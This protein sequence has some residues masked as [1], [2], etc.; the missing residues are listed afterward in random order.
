[1]DILNFSNLESQILSLLNKG[2]KTFENILENS[3]LSEKT[4]AQV[5]EGLISK[6]IILL[7][8]KTN[9]YEYQ[10]KVN[11]EVLILDGNLLLPT[12]IIRLKDKI[13]VTRGEWYEFPVD[14]DIRRI[15]WN[16]KLDNK[17]NSTLV[18]LIRTSILKEKKSKL[19]Q[20]TEYESLVNKIVPY[21]NNIGLLIHCISETVT[22]ISIIFKIKLSPTEEISI[23]HR[24]FTVRSEISTKEL[25]DEL[26]LPTNERNYKNIKLNQLFNF[27]DFIFSKNEIPLQLK[28]GKL[29]Y[30]KI[31]GIKKAL[32]LTYFELGQ[33]GNSKKINIEEFEDINESMEQLRDLFSNMAKSMLMENN[34]FVELTE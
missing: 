8:N 11:G 1:M 7:N 30:V 23:E 5:I 4:L 17:T 27:S 16:V 33:D 29:T 24:G 10:T 14:F 2:F 13:L 19:V 15:I 18:D 32:E 34:I 9:Q 31:T 25:L 22:D 21:N 6:N 12:T 20:L 26:K 3:G 28:N